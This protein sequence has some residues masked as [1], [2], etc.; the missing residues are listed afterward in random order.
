MGTLLVRHSNTRM[1]SLAEA[2]RSKLLTLE[3][4]YTESHCKIQK[5]PAPTRLLAIFASS[6]RNT[7]GQL[8]TSVIVRFGIKPKSE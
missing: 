3:T 8:Q 7:I 1:R 4:V 5:G 2:V 6:S